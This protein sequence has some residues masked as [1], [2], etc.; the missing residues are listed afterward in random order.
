MRKIKPE[1]E[2]EVVSQMVEELK[3]NEG[4]LRR[5]S[6]KDYNLTKSQFYT[7]RKKAI[8]L[9]SYEHDSDMQYVKVVEEKREQ[10]KT[11]KKLKEEMEDMKK[12]HT[13]EINFMNNTVEDAV[14]AYYKIVASNQSLRDELRSLMKW[15]R[16]HGGQA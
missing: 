5:E 10:E 8:Y 9:L 1:R 12:Q 7:L 3:R 14:E 16:D 15:V 6:F 4:R 13:A 11:I 2:R